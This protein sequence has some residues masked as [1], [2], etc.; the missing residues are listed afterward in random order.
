MLINLED[1]EIWKLTNGTLDNHVTCEID[2]R[3]Y[4]RFACLNPD[5]LVSVSRED[6]LL[7]VTRKYACWQPLC[8]WYMGPYRRNTDSAL[9]TSKQS[10][11]IKTSGCSRRNLTL[12][13]LRKLEAYYD[14]DVD[15]VCKAGAVVEKKLSR[16]ARLAQAPNFSND[17]WSLYDVVRSHLDTDEVIDQVFE[18]LATPHWKERQE[19]KRLAV[20]SMFTDRWSQHAPEIQVDKLA[21][22]GLLEQDGVVVDMTEDRCCGAAP[23]AGFLVTRQ[24]LGLFSI[25]ELRSGHFKLKKQ[26]HGLTKK[27]ISEKA[28]AYTCIADWPPEQAFVNLVGVRVFARTPET[29]AEQCK[30]V[31]S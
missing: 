14:V 17:I 31:L 23:L 12:V 25:A 9:L 5:D 22:L 27:A 26:F 13:R 11:F 24:W 16:H 28:K 7:K 29:V 18:L 2:D 21:E 20:S 8:S 1:T 6:N 19:N 4:E 10:Y 30:H 15:V 3:P